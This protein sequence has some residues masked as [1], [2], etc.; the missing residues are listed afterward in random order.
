MENASKALLMAGGILIA[1]VIIGLLLLMFNRIAIMKNSKNASLEDSQIIAFNKE[2]EKY[3][4][5]DKIRGVDFITLTN[6]VIDYKNGTGSSNGISDDHEITIV[7]KNISDYTSLHILNYKKFVWNTLKNGDLVIN[8]SSSNKNS[9]FIKNIIYARNLEE[10]NS[11]KIM[12]AV[13]S[14]S[15][16]ETLKTSN[17]KSVVGTGSGKIEDED[18][19]DIYKDYSEFKGVEFKLSEEPEYKDRLVTKI[20]F[21]CK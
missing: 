7:L 6:K 5:T 2:F 4:D 17:Y 11:L 1:L 13:K 19:F 8:G 21:E 14:F 12:T 15:S 18:H 20:V 16:F 9:D 10:S 3:A